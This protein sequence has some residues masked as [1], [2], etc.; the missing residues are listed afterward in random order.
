[1][2]VAS[3]IATS[4]IKR[5]GKWFL[6]C[7]ATGLLA[8]AAAVVFHW[9]MHVG[10]HFFLDWWAGFRPSHPA[11]D[12]P[13]FGH[14]HT[15][16]SELRLWLLPAAGGLLT[17]LL[18]AVL[19]PEAAGHGTDSAIFAYHHR[20]GVIPLRVPLVKTFAS[21]LTLGT[22]GSGGSEGPICQIGAGFGSVL[23]QRLGLSRRAVRIL[24]AAGMGAGIGSIFRA[25]M[26]G[27][28]FAAEI[29]YREPE[30]EAEVIIP[31]AI[32]SIVAY[33]LFCSV[34]GWG[35][36][37]RAEDFR[38]T[39]ALALGPYAVLSLAVAV[40]VFLFVRVFW[41][42]HDFFE[43]LPWPAW[44]KPAVGGLLTGTL[45]LAVPQVLGFSYGFIQEGLYNQVP[46]ALFLLVGLAKILAT[47]FSIGSGGSGGVFGPSVVIGGCVGGAVGQVFH[48][49]LPG[50]VPDPAPFVIVGMAGFF[51]GSSKVPVTAVIVVSEI[52]GSYHLLLP[53]L[54]VCS[55]SYFLCR[56][57]NLYRAQVQ[58]RVSSPAH[59]GDFFTDVL[60][61]IRVR[62]IFNPDKVVAIIPEDMSFNQFR[63]F[64]G[65]TDQ[66][67]FPVVDSF[68]RLTGIFSI[69]DVRHSLFDEGLGG[70][71]VMRDIARRDII[72]TTPS[73]DINTLL[74]KF[75]LRNIDQIP[76]VAD[77]DPTRFLGMVSRREAIALYNQAVQQ[78]KDAAA[79]EGEE[80]APPF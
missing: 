17:G 15:P 23:A 18:V 22:G 11:G 72:T 35:S 33:S 59:R 7:I 10:H 44:I 77:D 29:L 80:A 1:M 4:P 41:G 31:A 27:A 3:D 55:L 32:A 37:F 71:V 43:R 8:G 52:T 57:W 47:S 6:Y 30:F 68:G 9:L 40:A 36:L 2:P 51:A 63:L 61:D 78:I 50:I 75:T 12:P 19:S 16:L 73:E 25:P 76:V 62:D 54:L 20:E 5:A 28:L 48:H 67:Y 42:T 13:L 69:N 56:P 34:Y 21:F 60:E 49:L 79:K 26:T 58:N 65:R 39:N 70:L 14:S 38:F 74:R 24:M 46:A 64:F 45:A 66:H 53:S